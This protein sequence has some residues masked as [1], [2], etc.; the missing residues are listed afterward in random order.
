MGPKTTNERKQ[1]MKIERMIAVGFLVALGFGKAE[2]WDNAK[3]AD[4]LRQVPERVD[5]EKVPADQLET[6][7]Q[8]KALTDAEDLKVTGGEEKEEAPSKG[9]KTTAKGKPA[10][11]AKGKKSKE[12]PAAKT[13][14]ARETV[15]TDA[16]G[17]R[18]GT[19]RN[20]VNAV[21]SEEWQDYDSI[22]KAS[23]LKEPKVR[24]WLN[25]PHIGKKLFEKRNFVQ[26][27][28]K[29]AKPAK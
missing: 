29:P 25:N 5:V 28:L 16:Y 23:G 20:T 4:R 2:A 8:L 14:P 13:K 15:A 22:V 3:L 6:Y 11:P 1:N 18:V 21:M 26:Y 7:E 10:A 24:V 19:V 12:E 17:C 9:K 27:R